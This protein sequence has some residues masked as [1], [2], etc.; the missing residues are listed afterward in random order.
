MWFLGVGK[1][2]EPEKKKQYPV[3]RPV[4]LK[5]Q[6]LKRELV[7]LERDCELYTSQGIVE[8]KAGD[9]LVPWSGE[10]YV[11]PPDKIPPDWVFKIGD[12]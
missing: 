7:A 2:P 11:I 8:A 10:L 9:L 3:L 5:P 1:E 12:K 6:E 4:V